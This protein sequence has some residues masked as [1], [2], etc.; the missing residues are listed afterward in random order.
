MSAPDKTP[1]LSP[2]NVP[3]WM[4]LALAIVV[5]VMIVLPH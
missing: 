4:G 5:G 3:L 2:R 1:F